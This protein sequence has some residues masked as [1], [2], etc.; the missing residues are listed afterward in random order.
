MTKQFNTADSYERPSAWIRLTAKFVLVPFIWLSSGGAT[1]AQIENARRDPVT[2]LERLA[3][4]PRYNIPDELLQQAIVAFPREARQTAMV[5]PPHPTHAERQAVIDMEEI[6]R[7][8]RALRGTSEVSGN[9]VVQSGRRL[10]ALRAG[11]NDAHARI[12]SGF[13]STEQLFETVS[14]PRE[15]RQ[16]QQVH[17]ALYEANWDKLLTHL[18]NAEVA[19]TAASREAGLDQAIALLATSHDQR[20]NQ[21]F[22]PGRLP[23]SVLRTEARA[24]R[25]DWV[26]ASTEDAIS[27]DRLLAASDAQGD[28]PFLAPSDTVQ[29]TPAIE[30]LALSLGNNPV[31]I[32]RWVKNNIDFYPTFGSLQGS[33]L[34][35]DMRRGNATDISSLLVALLRSAGIHARFVQGTV[36][37]PI[38]DVLNWLGDVPD[39]DLAQ[40]LLGAGAIPNVAILDG[41]GNIVSFNV[42]HVWVEA[43]ID[44]IP[45]RGSV[46]LSGDSWVAMDASFKRYLVTPPSNLVTNVPLDPV[47]TDIKDSLTVNESLG[48]F[49]AI[50]EEATLDSMENWAIDALEYMANN[51]IEQTPTAIAGDKQIVQD[52]I[53]LLPGTLP[54]KVLSSSAPMAAL[55]ASLKQTVR[56]VGYSSALNRSLDTPDFSTTISFG[57]LGSGRLALT[58]TPAT[59]ADE[60]VLQAAIDAGATSLPIASVNV[61]PQLTVDGVVQSAGASRRMGTDYFLNVTVD[62]PVVAQTLPYD[63]I[64]GDEIVVGVTGNGFLPNVLQARLDANP[65]TTSAEYLHQVNLHYWSESD[66]LNQQSARG[67]GGYITRLPSV[68][69]FSSPLTVSLLFGQPNTGVYASKFMDVN[70]SFIGAAA[71]TGSEKVALV[72][73]AGFNGSYMEGTTFDQFETAKTGVAQ[74]KAVDSMKLL[75]AANAQDI[76]LYRITPSNKAN[77]LPLLNLDAADESNIASALAAGQTV[78]A[79]RDNI[80]IGP[81]SGAGY[82]LQNETTGEGAYLISGGLN[83]GGLAD[84]E[85]DLVKKVVPVLAIIAL[86]IIA[87]ILL[88]YLLAALAAATAAALAGAGAVAAEVWGAFVLMMRGLAVLAI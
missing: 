66:F 14:L 68:G 13:A 85:E 59:P 5:R 60:A 62:G 12:E 15:I 37:I 54:F 75:S 63:V 67:M 53:M 10:N 16:R 2:F 43:F 83:G 7:Q 48:S 3:A 87:I 76:P 41:G 19:P 34:T 24:P 28:D 25:S 80:N 77:V 52:K 35:L 23:F 45:S 21:I 6:T 57:A 72:K 49:D 33:Q 26:A 4:D 27:A 88:Y 40:D 32:Y 56:V 46:N 17:R 51:N 74:I 82:I 79:P 61:I 22:D 47:L 86:S 20:P 18:N 1:F 78:L 58:F 69:L 73:Q 36:D 71:A 70:W 50:D 38:A 84:C 9:R 44:M 55:P 39:A 81:W 8:L 31:A 11:L 30:A 29:I 65:I 42:E 64:A